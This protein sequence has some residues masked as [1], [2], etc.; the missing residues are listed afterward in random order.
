[1]YIYIIIHMVLETDI[2]LIE[3]L[4]EPAPRYRGRNPKLQNIFTYRGKHI[5]ENLREERYMKGEEFDDCMKYL[6]ISPFKNTKDIYPIRLKKT[7]QYL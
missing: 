7:Y 6:S 1:M 3:K 2:A 5:L 4:F